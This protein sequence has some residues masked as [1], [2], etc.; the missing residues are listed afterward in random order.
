MSAE[1]INNKTEFREIENLKTQIIV[2]DNYYNSYVPLIDYR[3][4]KYQSGH[5]W[6]DI[7]KYRDNYLEFEAVKGLSLFVNGKFFKKYSSTEKENISINLFQPFS[8]GNHVFLSFSHPTSRWPRNIKVSIKTISY[9]FDNVEN[10]SIKPIIKN[11]FSSFV[12]QC[13]ILIL[14]FIAF[15]KIFFKNTTK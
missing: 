12:I 2:F 9:R 8:T 10:N 1:T 4:T 15:V 7:L 14:T 6:L 11:Y 13:L 3:D 5:L